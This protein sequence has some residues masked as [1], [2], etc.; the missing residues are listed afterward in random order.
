MQYN[1]VKSGTEFSEIPAGE[2]GK[3]SKTKQG[4]Q[5]YVQ[6]ISMNYICSV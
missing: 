1:L 4:N 6:Q 3:W 5:I 2:G